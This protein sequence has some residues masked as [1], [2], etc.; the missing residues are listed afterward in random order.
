MQHTMPAQRHRDTPATLHLHLHCPH[1]RTR[2]RTTPPPTN[3]NRPTLVQLLLPVVSHALTFSDTANEFAQ[4]SPTLHTEL[5]HTLR[6]SFGDG[7]ILQTH[8]GVTVSKV[9]DAHGTIRILK[10]ADPMR[11]DAK[12]RLRAEVGIMCELHERCKGVG[13]GLVSVGIDDSGCTTH[14]VMKYLERTT[15]LFQYLN[16]LGESD[17]VDFGTAVF[18]L[19]NVVDTL[20]LMRAEGFVHGDIKAEN[21]MVRFDETKGV[22]VAAVLIDFGSSQCIDTATTAAAFDSAAASDVRR[23]GHVLFALLTKRMLQP[24][25]WCPIDVFETCIEQAGRFS[26]PEIALVRKIL[27]IGQPSPKHL[28]MRDIQELLEPHSVRR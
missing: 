27:Q 13:P 26:E 4:T 25:Q 2:I 8:A 21:I 19:A 11:A 15:E 16:R 14:L 1:I 12:R 18:I 10:S 23:L 20:C 3:R 7:E 28:S 24:H 5:A 17:F 6:S 9:T 22:P